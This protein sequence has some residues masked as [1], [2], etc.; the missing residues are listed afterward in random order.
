[1]H[2][3]PYDQHTLLVVD[4]RGAL[5]DR[6]E[7]AFTYKACGKSSE[8]VAALMGVSKET[9]N[10]SL[11]KAYIKEGVDHT[12][13]P[14]TLL[15]TK[16]FHSGWMKFVAFSLAVIC[17]LPM[18]ARTRAPNVRNNQPVASARILKTSREIS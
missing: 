16:A 12:D 7:E 14:F 11:Q 17:L 2:S 10:K 18:E 8:A 6:Q 1:M 15:L 9:V 4:S 3:I 13:S 5:A